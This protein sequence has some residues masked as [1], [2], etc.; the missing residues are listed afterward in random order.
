MA[1]DCYLGRV[2]I[3]TYPS[4]GSPHRCEAY[5]VVAGRARRELLACL[6]AGAEANDHLLP[7]A[8]T[9][10]LWAP[11]GGH[12]PVGALSVRGPHVAEFAAARVAL[13]RFDA[14]LDANS[15]EAVRREE[16][17]QRRSDAVPCRCFVPVWFGLEADFEN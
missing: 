1:H 16:T 7:M 8:F 14:L 13:H 5:P 12:M 9:T 17:A 2:G 10:S 3:E 15:S 11:V 6:A 4:G